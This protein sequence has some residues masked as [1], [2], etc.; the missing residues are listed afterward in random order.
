VISG[1]L[2]LKKAGR[3]SLVGLCPFHTE[4]TASLSVSPSKQVYYCFGCG[5]GGN[6]FNFLRKVEGLS[7]GEAVELLAKQAGVTLRYEGQTSAGRKAEGR[8]QAIHQA[9]AD[10][11]RLYHRTLLEEPAG[12]EARR[13]VASRGITPESIERF[14]IGYAPGASDFLLKRLSKMYSTELLSE[15]GLV[16]RDPSGGLRDQFR[17][18]VMFPVHDLSG[19]AVGFGGRL[20]PGDKSPAK[21]MNSPDGPVY[22]KSTLLYNL[23]R[24]KGEVTR[25]ER[26]FVVEG[27]TDVIA[28]DQAGVRNAVATCGTAFGEDHVRQLARFADRI[29]LAFDSDEA[30][31]RAAERAFQ[32]H[33]LYPV[34]LSV[35]VLP[36]GQDPADFTLA[37]GGEAF[38]ALADRAIP[39][40][41]YMLDRIVRGKDLSQIEQRA[42]IVREGLAV[43]AELEDPV[44]REEYARQLAGRVGESENSVMLDLERVLARQGAPSPAAEKVHR[45]RIPGEE[46]EWE[47]LKLLVQAPA[48]C[49]PWM[50]KL[51][52]E[53]FG[54]PTHRKAFE[55]IMEANSNGGTGDVSA[56]V[57]RAQDRSGEQVARLLAGLAVERPKSEAEPTA[58]YVGQLFMRLEEFSLKRKADSI[59]RELERVNPLKSPADHENL[60]QQLIELEGARR[61]I[62]PS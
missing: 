42:H 45:A 54:K 51:H 5:E 49:L 59:R 43:V 30:G 44:S 53:Q 1:Y 8:R 21:Y 25:S 23:N 3:D 29:V 58:E 47:V 26:V 7:F 12:A 14:V 4:K 28:L 36:E 19:S 61:R 56:L 10:A 2:Q 15:A 16:G 6:V 55:T 17:A 20:L 39:L 40:M 24:A 41:G 22:H 34:Q 18:R 50:A 9:I 27:Y 31:A 46:V 60:F 33:Q 37:S 57:A 35:L 11:A 48:L 32:F 13:Y 62:R 38:T 52:S